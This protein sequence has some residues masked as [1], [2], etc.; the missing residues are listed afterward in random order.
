MN[1]RTPFPK[2]EDAKADFCLTFKAKTGNDFSVPEVGRN[3]QRMK[4]KY[5]L[6]RITYSTVNHQDYM[7]PFDFDNC[8][9]AKGIDSSILELIEEIANITM[10]QKAVR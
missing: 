3:F 4:K 5:D 6:A 7:A 9:K 2:L 1:Q 8:P 10:F